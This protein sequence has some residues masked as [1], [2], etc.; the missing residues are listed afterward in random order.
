MKTTSQSLASKS[1]GAA[2]EDEADGVTK[3]KLDAVRC[4]STA[5]KV[6]EMLSCA[7][8][9]EEV[10]P[11]KNE[12]C[13][14]EKQFSAHRKLVHATVA[15]GRLSTFQSKACQEFESSGQRINDKPNENFTNKSVILLKMIW[16]HCV[17]RESAEGPPHDGALR[18]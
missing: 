3:P 10:Q 7:A 14:E 2:P 13:A 11:T 12:T 5:E 17:Y 4:T 15:A 6:N 1:E 8:A 9:K 18:G 16:N